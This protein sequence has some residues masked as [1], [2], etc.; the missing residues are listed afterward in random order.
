MNLKTNLYGRLRN[1]KLAKK[2]ALMPLFEAVIN[3]IHSIEESSIDTSKSIINIEILTAK[4]NNLNFHPDTPE[5]IGF[6]ITDNGVG[7]NDEN[8]KSFETL[9]SDYKIE[10]G[11]RGIGRLLWL[12]AFSEVHIKSVYSDNAKF[13]VRTFNFNTNGISNLS[14]DTIDI[15]SK[16]NNKTVVT[17]NGFFKE[18]RASVSKSIKTIANKLFEHC[19]WYFIREKGVPKITISNDTETIALDDIY[20]ENIHSHVLSESIEIKKNVFKLTHAKIRTKAKRP[21]ILAYCAASRIVIEENVSGKL[22]GLFGT[23]HDEKGNF[24]YT[25][26]LNSKYLDEKVYSERTGFDISE[27]D[28]KIF[29]KSE[30][31]ISEIR[32]CILEHSKKY[33]CESLDYNIVAGKNRIDQ[34][35]SDKAPHYQ[36]ILSHIENESFIVDPSAPDKK[37]ELF[38]HQQ[39]VE[40]ERKLLEDGHQ[41]V[42][43]YD[44]DLDGYQERLTRYLRL[45]ADIK[46]SNLVNYVLHRKIVLDILDKVIKAE[47]EGRYVRESLIHEMLIPMGKSSNEIDYN[48][49]NLWIIDE[50]LVFHNYLASDK[51]INSIPITDDRSNQRPDICSLRVYDNPLLI[52][53]KQ[54]LPL[55]SITIIEIKR[56]MRNDSNDNP[57]KQALT[58]L[59]RIRSGNVETANGRLIPESEN[60]PGYCYII[61]DLTPSIKEQCELYSLDV[62]ADYM[63]YFGYVKHYKA[64]VE[65]VSYDKLVNTAKERNRAFFE[66]LGLPA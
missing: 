38:L 2:H 10:K 60:I 12:K 37:I 66:K 58:Y 7:F 4:Q 57:I 3:S 40:I 49:N 32:E 18:Y 26:Y 5:I 33:L 19:L 13:K 36:S 39:K 35:I 23:L 25:C 51:T 1:T 59:K 44:N 11:C 15:D 29:S 27:K 16:D 65:V 52:S 46:Q 48:A 55:A 28:E 47:K 9:D 54:T 6:R 56:P 50:R 62:S 21:H 43:S 17:L 64:F 63:G 14:V 53:E 42:D 24:V 20:K 45:A 31:S 8:M 30:I 61:S 22:P 34:F 41:V